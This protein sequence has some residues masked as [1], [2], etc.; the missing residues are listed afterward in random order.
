MSNVP[1]Y[2][3]DYLKI[4]KGELKE[5]YNLTEEQAA[6]AVYKSA[7][8]S[9]LMGDNEELRRFQMH[10]SLEAT[11]LDVYR[12]YKNI[13]ERSSTRNGEEEIDKINKI[14]A[15]DESIRERHK[16]KVRVLQDIPLP[17]ADDE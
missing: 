16:E 11:V 7:V 1:E 17:G 14:E 9:I 13:G 12:Q 15:Q 10:K 3:Q 6:K 5:K 4:I 8:R 2:I